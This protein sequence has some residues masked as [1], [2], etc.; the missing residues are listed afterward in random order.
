[1]ELKFYPALS[2]A[3]EED[4]LRKMLELCDREFVPPLSGRTSTTQGGF[5]AADGTG[6]DAYLQ[7]MLA[8]P[9]ILALEEGRVAAFLSYR[10]NYSCDHISADSFPN[11]YISTVIVHPDFRGKGI[12]RLFYETI[13]QKFSHCGIYTRTWSTNAAQEHVLARFGFAELCRIPD[14]RGPGIDTVYYAHLP[15]A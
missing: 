5:I 6:V 9:G 15:K 2:L 14:H 3:G 4:A 12:L 11:C 13:L 7:A 1:M 8:Q 10:E